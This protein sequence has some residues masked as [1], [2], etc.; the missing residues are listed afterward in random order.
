MGDREVQVD[1]TG[2]AGLIAVKTSL[3]S[4]EVIERLRIL[5]K[6]KPHEL[7]YTLRAIPIERIVRTNLGDIQQAVTEMADKIDAS[8][9]FRVTV[10]KRFTSIPTRGIIEAAAAGIQRKVDLTKPD[11][12]VLIEVVGGRTGVS[13]IKPE[14][15][16]STT[17]EMA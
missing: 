7:R 4:L 14:D 11:K 8:E 17:K 2:I 3:S 16:F 12:L 6:E 1:K 9:T 15:V 5:F 13:V 10:E